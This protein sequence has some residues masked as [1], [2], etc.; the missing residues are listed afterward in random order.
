MKIIDFDIVFRPIN[1]TWTHL[2]WS[3][4]LEILGRIFW[5]F[6]NNFL[7]KSIVERGE[8]GFT[9]LFI[10]NKDIKENPHADFLNHLSIKFSEFKQFKF[11]WN[12]IDLDTVAYDKFTQAFFKDQGIL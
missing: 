3:K 6:S 1:A 5:E 7:T 2:S 11:Y 10:D 9:I 8:S 12:N 4:F